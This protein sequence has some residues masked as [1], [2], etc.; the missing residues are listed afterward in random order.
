MNYKRFNSIEEVQELVE[1]HNR[2]SHHLVID[3]ETTSKN[4]REAH[5]VDIQI[6]GQ[7]KDSVVIFDADKRG[8]LVNLLKKVTLVAHNAKYDLQVLFRHGVDLLSHRF[9]DTL[10][11]AHLLDENKDSYSLG[12]LVKEYWNDEYK[13]KFWKEDGGKYESYIEAP[14]DERERYACLDVWYTE[15][16]YQKIISGLAIQS[17]PRSLIEHAHRLQAALLKTEI[18]GIRVDLQYLEQLGVRT[19]QRLNELQPQMRSLVKYDLSI[20]ELQMWEKELSTRKTAQ[21]KVRVKKPVFN[22]ESSRQLQNL[23]YNHLGLPKQRNSKTKQISTDYESLQKIKDNHPIIPLIQE[24]RD[25][26]KIYTAYIEGTYDRLHNERIYPE[27]RV[28]GTVT[29]RL[30]HSNPNLAQLPKE[31]GVRGIYVPDRGRRLI[32]ADYSQLE[33]ILEANLTGDKSLIRMLENGESKHDLTARELGCDRGTAK[34]LNFALQYWASHYKVAKLLGCSNDEGKRIWD[35][36]WEIYPGAKELKAKTDKMVDSGTPI[37]NLFGR[38]RRFSI[39]DREAWD[40][41]YRQAYN[42]LIQSTGAD[43]TSRA[44]YLVEERLSEYGEGRA[45][46]TVHDEVI[47]EVKEESAEAWN[48]YLKEIMIGVGEDLGLKIPLQVES[49]GPMLRWED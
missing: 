40:S 15:R 39:H 25:L 19:K 8:P 13:E 35:R 42:F 46:F 48:E 24:N 31:G 29:G 41:D 30:S 14:T 4:S 20:L 22:F 1:Y 45:L 33:V 23:L 49:S 27:F 43:I 16:L 9:H 12:N 18:E 26:Q 3:V 5:L 32:S 47:I 37:T 34:T 17:I 36:Y 44:F 2:N 10:I 21:G 28:S 6:T 38:K 7:D 11:L